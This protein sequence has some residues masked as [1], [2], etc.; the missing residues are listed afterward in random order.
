MT[1]FGDEW[2][3]AVDAALSVGQR[4]APTK[5]DLNAGCEH[6]VRL[7]KDAAALLELG[8]YATA[9]FLSITAIEETAKVHIGKYRR[10]AQQA[11]R[12]K[13]PLFKHE[14]KHKLGLGPTVS[15]GGRLKAAVGE[16]RLRELTQLAQSGEL[17]ALREAALYVEQKE[18]G[19]VVPAVAINPRLSR[20]LFLLAI[21]AFDDALVGYTNRSFEL[22]AETDH[23]FEQWTK[24]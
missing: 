5:E 18:K 23:L 24:A 11:P 14:Q 7:L 22:G 2:W 12:R 19:L 10:S 6:V 13:D 1:E 9:A 4:I 8:S 21:E 16:D 15:M 17:V 20:D 3:E